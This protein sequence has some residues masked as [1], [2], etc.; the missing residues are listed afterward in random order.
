[1]FIALHR[2]SKEV[3]ENNNRILEKYEIVVEKE[4]EDE[5]KSKEEFLGVKRKYKIGDGIHTYKELD[6]EEDKIPVAFSVN[7]TELESEEEYN[8]F[9]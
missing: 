7:Y 5:G 1:M 2:G 6:Y 8:P 3:L 9:K 4:P